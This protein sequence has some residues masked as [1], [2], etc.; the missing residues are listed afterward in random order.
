MVG[1][2][3]YRPT[4]YKPSH[5]FEQLSARQLANNSG[6]ATDL[7]LGTGGQPYLVSG[8]FWDLQKNQSFGDGCEG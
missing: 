7:R 4:L 3:E 5:H 2:D 6:V 8:G 1:K